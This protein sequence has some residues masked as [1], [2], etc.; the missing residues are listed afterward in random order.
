MKKKMLS[1]AL[2]LVM[3]LSLVPSAFAAEAKQSAANKFTDVSQTAWYLGELEYAV[4]NGY[5]SGTSA[6]TFSPDANITRGQFVTIL[7]RMLGAPTS[8]GQTK[9]TDVNPS[10]WYAPYVAWAAEK[11]YVNGTSATT[12]TP[13][14]NITV[15]QMATII[16]NYVNKSGVT[17]NGRVSVPYTD[18]SSI[19]TWAKSSMKMMERYN[20]LVT[21]E[22]GK[23]FPQKQVSRAEGTVTLARLAK[24]S[25]LGV[26]PVIE[27]T[28]VVTNPS[29]TKTY[30]YSTMSD[31]DII[32]LWVVMRAYHEL[33]ESGMITDTTPLKDRAIYYAWWL[34]SHSGYD[35]S[36]SL[37]NRH[38]A[39]GALVDWVSVCDG[40]AYAYKML[41][42]YEGI[43]CV[44]VPDYAHQ[45]AYNEVLIDGAWYEVDPQHTGGC[46]I[47][48]D[49]KFS[50]SGFEGAY[51]KYMTTPVRYES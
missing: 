9:F 17:L 21:G 51:Q 22:A 5:I 29:G 13:E 36:Q 40:H 7:G 50:Q 41:M 24:A 47:S 34:R 35:W 12:F 18:E 46:C 16:A 2:A 33:R 1:L 32:C 6:S 31:R 28:A 11:E 10:S 27:K 39:Y 3:C 43:E 25:G 42:D 26:D 30:D 37:P 44:F 14:A 15:E 48:L 8:S 23:V 20:L 45:H 38:T 49:G 19:S 4:Y